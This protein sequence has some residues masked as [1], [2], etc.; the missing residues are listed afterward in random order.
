MRKKKEP[1]FHPHHCPDGH[2][3]Q[4]RLDTGCEGVVNRICAMHTGNNNRS[5]VLKVNPS[6]LF[7]VGQVV[8]EQKTKEVLGRIETVKFGLFAVKD[9]ER[10]WFCRKALATIEDDVVFI[11][12]Q[13]M[14]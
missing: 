2:D 5:S 4:C 11:N 8:V 14:R 12:R 13:A 10:R 1:K 7:H 3:Y 9:G 6:A